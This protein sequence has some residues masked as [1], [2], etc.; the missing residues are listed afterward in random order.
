MRTDIFTLENMDSNIN[1]LFQIDVFKTITTTTK[2]SNCQ[3]QLLFKANVQ[4]NNM[5]HK[6]NVQREQYM[7][8]VCSI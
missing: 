3:V 7:L 4:E 5:I 2:V 6:S 1:I 8:L